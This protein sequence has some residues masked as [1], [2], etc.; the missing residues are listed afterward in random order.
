MVGNW[1]KTR[2]VKLSV[3]LPVLPLAILLIGCGDGED[4]ALIPTPASESQLQPE[5]TIALPPTSVRA[6]DRYDFQFV[7][8]FGG[9][10]WDRAVDIAFLPDGESALVADQVGQVFQAFLN[11]RR[12]PILTFSIRERTSRDS[13]EEGLLSLALDPQYEENG[14]VWMYYSVRGGI[15]RTR[16]S[17]FTVDE[18]IADW[19]SE[20]IVYELI[21]PYGNHN[22]GK[23][24]FDNHGLLYLAFGDG[25]SLG[26]PQSNGQDVTNVYGTIIRLD[27]SDSNGDEPYR[28][29]PD[30]PYIGDADVLDEIWAFGLRNPWRMWFDGETEL[31]WIGD[32]GQSYREEINVVDTN[33]G[34]GTNFGWSTMEGTA[35]FKPRNDCNQTGMALPIEDYPPRSGHCSVI[36]GMVYRGAEIP[37]LV[38]SFLFSDHCKGELRAMDAIDWSTRSVALKPVAPEGTEYDEPGISSFGVDN[39][40]EI[41]VLRFDGAILKMV[42]GEETP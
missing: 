28:I 31:L 24:V 39:E 32:V 17:W 3:L 37:T 6:Y 30:N 33:S 1:V 2:A 38:D 4:P 25:G 41:Y 42:P 34:G 29:P 15:R 35:C 40:G 19:S 9:H 26:D 20:H 23:I 12:D 16:L 10:V 8:V 21:Q 13:N 7:E 22:G 11:A 14:R 36:A 18:Y 5:A 27:I